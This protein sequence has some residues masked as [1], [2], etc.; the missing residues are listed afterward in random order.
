MSNHDGPRG[1]RSDLHYSDGI[2]VLCPRA[3]KPLEL[4]GGQCPACGPVKSMPIPLAD[5]FCACWIGPDMARADLY[6]AAAVLY[7]R[8]AS[9]RAVA[10]EVGTSYG[11][12]RDLREQWLAR[13]VA[14]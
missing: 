9:I 6:D 1:A 11:T 10:R 4:T 3:G 13:D 14:A 5:G 12:A 2:R 8:G 7:D